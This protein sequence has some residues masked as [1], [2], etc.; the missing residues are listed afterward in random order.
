MI[1]NFG[2]KFAKRK[3]TFLR[4]VFLCSCF[5]NLLLLQ[6]CFETE[7]GL[8]CFKSHTDQFKLVGVSEKTP[9]MHNIVFQN[10]NRHVI[11]YECAIEKLIQN[12]FFNCA[13]K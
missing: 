3:Q 11:A 9:A 5:Y 2:M 12:L 13:P 6:H 1:S 4:F 7:C 8:G 10:A